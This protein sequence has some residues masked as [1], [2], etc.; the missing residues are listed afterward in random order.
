MSL[1]QYKSDLSSRVPNLGLKYFSTDTS[2][3]VCQP[4]KENATKPN[5]FQE[6]LPLTDT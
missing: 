4:G 2:F 3:L 1:A 6:C 5:S